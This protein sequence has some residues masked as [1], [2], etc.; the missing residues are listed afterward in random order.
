MVGSFRRVAI[1]V[2][3]LAS[4]LIALPAVATAAIAPPIRIGGNAASEPNQSAVAVDPDG[5]AYIAWINGST[6]ALQ[7]CK[8]APSST[9]CTPITLQ[10]PSGGTYDDPPSVIVSGLDVYVYEAY[11]DATADELNGVDEWASSDGGTSFTLLGHAVSSTQGSPSGADTFPAQ[12]PVIALPGGLIGIGYFS[13][14]NPYFQANTLVSPADD[15]DG[16][17]P[18]AYAQINPAGGPPPPWYVENLGG[19]QFAAD[20]SGILGVFTSAAAT[21]APCSS[22]E[23]SLVYSYA[24]LGSTTTIAQL[25]TSTGSAG[26]PWSYLAAA[27]TLCDL[28]N[29]AVAGGPSGLGMLETN[30]NTLSDELIQYSRFTP[31]ST[32]STP[33]T[34]AAGNGSSASVSQDSGAGVYAT[35]I[36]ADTGLTFAYSPN[37]GSDWYPAVT[38]LGNDDNAL[39]IAA[40][41]SSVNGAGA[42]WAA[43]AANGVEYAQPFNKV[44]A[45]PPPVKPVN[46]SKPGVS[47]SGGVGTKL[48][49]SAGSWTGSPT[50]TYQW[51]RNGTAI[52]GETGP[53]YT[54]GTIDEG[55]SFYCVVTATNAA[56]SASA[57]S[58]TKVVPIHYTKKCPPATGKMTGTQIGLLKLNMTRK[59]ARFVYRRHSNRGKQYQDF[60]CL[61][62]MGVR[63]G[64]A[65]P[66]LLKTL[67]KHE[68]NKYEDRVVW[69]STSN[70]YY[71]LDGVRAG[72]SIATAAAILHTGKPFHI[73][74]N[75][76]YLAV[77]HGYT[78]VLKVRGIQVQELG[79]ADNSLTKTRSDQST[80]MHSFY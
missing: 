28:E 37:G 10:Q 30:F 2:G 75:Y 53:T 72:E 66:K 17:P 35:W 63:A 80:L 71:Q 26:S 51:Y 42:G 8:L 61:T 34:I 24:P 25:N 31:P 56:G 77:K 54:V 73:G 27:T 47:G 20:S 5:N 7:F 13:I 62:P 32:W 33:V 57:H 52:A 19:D 36:D 58:N 65:T 68:R 48:T 59:Q 1:L 18:S 60:F 41:A 70:P 14:D 50:L 9:G 40:G 16:Q 11:D 43:Y 44:E 46:V 74:K 64:Y 12:D 69:A 39:S 3:V 49:C 6:G 29:P 4:A 38:L 23:E 67:P 22:A 79:I 15:S 45:I 21:N 78:A 76:W 55:S